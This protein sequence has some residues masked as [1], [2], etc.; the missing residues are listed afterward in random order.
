SPFPANDV[1]VDFRHGTLAGPQPSDFLLLSGSEKRFH[2]AAAARV[3]G[4]AV[5][6]LVRV[7]RPYRLVWATHGFTADGWTVAAR[8]GTLRFYGVGTYGLRRVVVVLASSSRA[9]LPLDFT[10][11]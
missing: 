3:G 1:R 11:R 9:A 6:Q 5:L 10:L 7:E 2:L 8:P 4:S